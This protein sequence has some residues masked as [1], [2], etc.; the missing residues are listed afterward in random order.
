[1]TTQVVD[2]ARLIT[3]KT[4]VLWHLGVWRRSAKGKRRQILSERIRVLSR[5]VNKM[6][7]RLE[8]IE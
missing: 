3:I 7:A 8:D 5:E 2:L 4:H 6:R 1:M